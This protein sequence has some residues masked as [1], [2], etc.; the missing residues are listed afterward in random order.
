M[1]TVRQADTFDIPW[2]LEELKLF[3]K[4]YGTKK[5]I[6]GDDE[7]SRDYITAVIKDHFI[8]V[9]EKA[10]DTL[11]QTG[12]IAGLVLNHPHNPR[13]KLLQELWWWVK[14]EHRGSGSGA[15]LFKEF[16]KF[17]EVHCDWISFTMEDNSPVP[18]EF[19]LTE[20]YRLK[21]RVFLREIN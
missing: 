1:I 6:Y 8:L 14:K 4:F 10:G 19:L 18:E 20:G 16:N 5:E 7:H 3:S 15:R 17:G 12:F 13:L 21:E 2:I 9:S 11:E